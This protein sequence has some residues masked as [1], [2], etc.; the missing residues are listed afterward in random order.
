MDFN[1]I[2]YVSI[3]LHQVE[4]PNHDEDLTSYQIDHHNHTPTFNLSYTHN[5]VL[6]VYIYWESVVLKL[7]KRKK[8]KKKKRTLMKKQTKKRE[9]DEDTLSLPTVCLL[10]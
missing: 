9:V 2:Q 5:N 7:E 4:V 3:L 10:N 8:K 1:R 6:K